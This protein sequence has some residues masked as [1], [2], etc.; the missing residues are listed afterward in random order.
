MRSEEAKHSLY[1]LSTKDSQYV[2]EGMQGTLLQERDAEVN[3]A[4][5][6]AYEECFW[7]TN[8]CRTQIIVTLNN[9][10]QCVGIAVV[11]NDA[12]FLVMVGMSKLSYGKSYWDHLSHRHKYVFIVYHSLPRLEDHDVD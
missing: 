12:Q 1:R 10:Q 11:Y 3:L 2:L 4:E 5:A 9:L 6:I 7:G 8:L